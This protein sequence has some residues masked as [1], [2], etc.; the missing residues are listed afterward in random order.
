MGFSKRY[1]LVHLKWTILIEKRANKECLNEITKCEEVYDEQH[2]TIDRV[3]KCTDYI[4]H[5]S[6]YSSEPGQ[7]KMSY[8][9]KT[10]KS[11]VNTDIP[12]LSDHEKRELVSLVRDKNISM[13]F[14]LEMKEAFLL[15][16]KVTNLFLYTIYIFNCKIPCYDKVAL[17][18]IWNRYNIY[19]LDIIS[20]LLLVM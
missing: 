7:N 13:D 15:F 18:Y 8:N 2:T 1:G 19:F 16:D 14:I 17:W 6:V 10:E 3:E 4:D 12:L 11:Q 9:K 20:D 5:H